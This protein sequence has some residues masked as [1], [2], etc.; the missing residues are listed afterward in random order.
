MAHK[1]HDD[2]GRRVHIFLYIHDSNDHPHLPRV[3][4]SGDF[5]F[6]GQS[7][8]ISRDIVDQLE[9]QSNIRLF[10]AL[11]NR[12]DKEDLCHDTSDSSTQDDMSELHSP[13]TNNHMDAHN[14]RRILQQALN[15]NLELFDNSEPIHLFSPLFFSR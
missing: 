9:Y 11:D 1:S 12:L 7:S 13:R 6:E 5:I 14:D 2:H 8:D 4:N 3:Q 15:S 10:T